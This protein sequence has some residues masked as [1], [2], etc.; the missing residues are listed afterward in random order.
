M[1]RY[2][3]IIAALSIFAFVSCTRETIVGVDDSV[4]TRNQELLDSYKK[5]LADAEHGWIAYVMT[6]QGYYRY[7]MDFGD[8]GIVNMMTDNTNLRSSATTPDE[9]Y[10][11]VRQKQRP[12]IV[13]ETYSYLS[14]IND[15]VDGI[16]GGTGH[17]G[18]E[19][20][21]EFEVRSLTNGVFDLVGRINRVPAKF[22]KATEE[23]KASIVA[24]DMMT[25]VDQVALL[26]GGINNFCSAKINEQTVGF[27]IKPRTTLAF[28]TD[29]SGAKTA[30][31][32]PRLEPLSR[33]IIFDTPMEVAGAKAS[34]LEWNG[35]DEKYTLKTD[36]GDFAI[37][38]TTTAPIALNEI[39]GYEKPFNRLR[40]PYTGTGGL[41]TEP[42]FGWGHL[43]SILGLRGV[44]GTTV[45]FS[46]DKSD[47]G[48]DLFCISTTIV[49]EGNGTFVGTSSY[50]VTFD[51]EDP[52][53]FTTGAQVTHQSNL[54][55]TIYGAGA[56]GIINSMG[57]KTFTM[58]WGQTTPPSGYET[59]TVIEFVSG[60]LIK[61]GIMMQ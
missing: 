59:E 39:F 31:E 58:R 7:W 28:Y 43:F 61:G 57:G 45:D 37:E 38:E 51:P 34:M 53:K 24:G 19:T 54:A 14:V 27:F 8:N 18:L 6:N 17:L 22:I 60:S 41:G 33:N 4:Y 35:T 36:K 11:S 26:T 23:Q 52:A 29:D 48:Q 42:S 44:G 12:T 56:A 25:E 20:D 49:Q 10:F 1:K 2:I 15:P 50:T 13:F 30:E 5:E 46:F 47:E 3:S 9:S 32:F 16:S 55:E 40:L 21:F